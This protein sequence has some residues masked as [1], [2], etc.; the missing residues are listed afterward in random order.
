MAS[1][2]PPKPSYRPHLPPAVVADGLLSDAQ[3]E[4]VIYAGEAHTGYLAG[5]WT[6]DDTFDAVS[7]ASDLGS[8]F[9]DPAVRALHGR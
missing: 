1:V 4:S 8:W 6:V 2:A 7:A 5:S 3:F 9:S